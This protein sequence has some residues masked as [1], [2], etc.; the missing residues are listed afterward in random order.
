MA[1]DT[2]AEL[3]RAAPAALMEAREPEPEPEP[4]P[5]REPE[6]EPEPFSEP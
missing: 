1:R 2:R 5:E 3:Q 6:P 4:G